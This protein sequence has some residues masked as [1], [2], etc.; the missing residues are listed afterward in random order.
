MKPDG[1]Y[2]GA[3]TRVRTSSPHGRPR[4][5]TMISLFGYVLVR[6]LRKGNARGVRVDEEGYMVRSERMTDWYLKSR[7]R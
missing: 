2:P 3:M 5:P 1:P 6:L 4:P 7:K